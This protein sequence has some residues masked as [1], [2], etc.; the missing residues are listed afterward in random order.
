MAAGRAPGDAVSPTPILPDFPELPGPWC[1]PVHPLRPSLGSYLE[2]NVRLLRCG[3]LPTADCAHPDPAQC[4]HPRTLPPFDEAAAHGLSA[5]EV[6]RRWPRFWG[7]CPH[8]GAR[9][10]GYASWAHFVAG[11]W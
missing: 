10:I 11:D 7:T 1:E 5:E 2:A 8:C 3:A 4:G 6:R 9:T